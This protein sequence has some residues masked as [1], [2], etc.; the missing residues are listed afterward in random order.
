MNL[1]F[2]VQIILIIIKKIKINSNIYRAKY[3]Y[4]NEGKDIIG[5]VKKMKMKEKKKLNHQMINKHQTYIIIPNKLGERI[6]IEP[7]P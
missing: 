1:L 5:Q 6:G 2:F 4:R 7:H 3:F